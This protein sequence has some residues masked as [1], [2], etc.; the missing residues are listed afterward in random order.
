MDLG[1]KES[2]YFKNLLLATIA[3]YHLDNDAYYKVI[4]QEYEY[5]QE[6]I[7]SF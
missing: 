6:A 2:R 4:S 7:I 3:R 1:T 5:M